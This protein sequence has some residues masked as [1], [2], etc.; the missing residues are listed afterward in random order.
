[1]PV[2]VCVFVCLSMQQTQTVLK[3][4]RCQT[5]GAERSNLG[6]SIL[7]VR[8]GIPAEISKVEE[9]QKTGHAV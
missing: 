9:I 1:M 3:G 5:E 6:L 2:S 7:P 4:N 8:A